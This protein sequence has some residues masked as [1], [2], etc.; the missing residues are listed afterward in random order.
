MIS[1]DLKF[2]ELREK[3]KKKQPEGILKVLFLHEIN[4]SQSK[5]TYTTIQPQLNY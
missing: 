2:W 3:K 1:L 4:L 5:G